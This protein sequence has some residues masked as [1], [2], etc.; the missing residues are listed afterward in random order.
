MYHPSL[1]SYAPYGAF[2]LWGFLLNFSKWGL[3]LAFPVAIRREAI[4]NKIK[5]LLPKPKL[6]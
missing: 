6:F 5:N 2:F 1:F 4:V 3:I